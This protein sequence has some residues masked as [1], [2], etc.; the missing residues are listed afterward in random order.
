MVRRPTPR[1]SSSPA[2]SR[3]PDPMTRARRTSAAGL[4][5]I[6][7]LMAGVAAARSIRLTKAPGVSFE[8]TVPTAHGKKGTLG[9]VHRGAAPTELPVTYTTAPDTVTVAARAAELP[10]RRASVFLRTAPARVS[11]ALR[12]V[13]VMRV[14][15]PAEVP[16]RR[17][18]DW[19][20]HP[21]AS[22]EV[23]SSSA[24]TIT[25]QAPDTERAVT[26][27]TRVPARAAAGILRVGEVSFQ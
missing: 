17:R 5:A 11:A 3:H 23:L 10:P 21:G 19:T 27:V 24:G 9:R 13:R 15:V 2:R 22:A 20:M 7:A 12:S 18:V 8:T 14:H 16:A 25:A 1:P 4:F 6:L 26:V